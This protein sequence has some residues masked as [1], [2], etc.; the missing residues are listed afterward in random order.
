MIEDITDDPVISVVFVVVT[1]IGVG[2]ILAKAV[3]MLEN[4]KG[5]GTREC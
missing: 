1:A 5:R 4:G 3:D 2:V